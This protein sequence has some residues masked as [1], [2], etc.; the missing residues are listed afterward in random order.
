MDGNMSVLTERNSDENE[1]NIFYNGNV[2]TNQRPET[3]YANS[4]VIKRNEGDGLLESSLN[5]NA[6]PPGRKPA[7]PPK[8]S[9]QVQ[10][11][12][13]KAKNFVQSARAAIFV[14]N[15][16]LRS[17]PGKKDPAEMSLKERLALFERN[18]GSALMPKAPLAMSVST[19]QIMADKKNTVE[20][21]K[22]PFLLSTLKNA[23]IIQSIDCKYIHL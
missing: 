11:N 5:N 1:K 8:P 21:L 19:K 10:T 15:P 2:A 9:S 4:N 18:K 16:L 12:T 22:A 3:I 6:I 14:R 13:S 20:H 17:P 7:L 23:K